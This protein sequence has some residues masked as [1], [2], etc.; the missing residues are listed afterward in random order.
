[1]VGSCH[2][3]PVFYLG[4]FA[5]SY[6][7][8]GFVGL[9]GTDLD[10]FSSGCLVRALSCARNHESQMLGFLWYCTVEQSSLCY[11]IVKLYNRR[12][13]LSH[14]FH[15][16]A[17]SRTLQLF[18]QTLSPLS[19]TCCGLPLLLL[20]RDYQFLVESEY[21]DF[22]LNTSTLCKLRCIFTLFQQGVDLHFGCFVSSVSWCPSDLPLQDTMWCYAVGKSLCGTARAER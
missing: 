19:N 21:A 7:Q 17:Y 12:N 18:L 22:I 3:C 8:R 20:F 16:L 15:L 14:V 10:A 13:R 6:R 9:A 1:M 5:A 2:D 4:V 11:D